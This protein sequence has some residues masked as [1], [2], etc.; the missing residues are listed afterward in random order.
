MGRARA[1][2]RDRSSG[3]IPTAVS[4][5]FAA[6]LAAGGA[7]HWIDTPAAAA[8][9]AG[10][11]ATG[12]AYLVARRFA[13]SAERER[14]A[15]ASRLVFDTQNELRGE[16]ADRAARRELDRALDQA[17]DEIAALVVIRHAL[18][19]HFPDR[20]IELHLVDPVEPLLTVRIALCRPN[21]VEGHHA[22][23]WEPLAIRTGATLVYET[24]Q[25]VDACPHVRA[26]AGAPSSAVAVPL[27]AT[28]RILGLI[29]AFGADGDA[30]DQSDVVL[31]EEFA[32]AIASR[33][34]LT[35][36][37]EPS[38]RAESID[39]LTGLPDRP[40][41][42]HRVMKLLG[43][44]TP[45]S[46][47]V[48]DIDNFGELN[49]EYGRQVGDESLALLGKV[50]REAIRPDDHVGRVGN[51]ELLFVLPETDPADATRAIERI[52]EELFVYQSAAERIP[53][54]TM[55]VGVVGSATGF[56]IEDIL[57]TAAAALR[58]ARQFGGNRIVVAETVTG[59][60]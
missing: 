5:G 11:T 39:G 51:D 33:L 48:A 46:V 1:T 38:G 2:P 43:E 44:R 7:S 18:A 50:S 22:S 53:R 31:L 13:G 20:P 45:F 49:R 3:A 32:S 15:A 25:R 4:V 12:V 36:I 10:A 59:S 34:A 47:G 28:G 60:T 37:P 23:A 17:E 14:D 8:A 27:T 29:Y 52:R 54:F 42:Q 58:A 24:T 16:R 57:K 41:M 40:A 9:I 21:E 30:P 26:R 6:A 55:S 19:R 56:A 35:R